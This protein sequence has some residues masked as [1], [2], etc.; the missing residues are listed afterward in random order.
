MLYQASLV[1]EGG[2]MAGVYTAGVL[3]VLMEHE[4]YFSHAIGVSIGSCNV[5]DFA[6]RQIGRTI[7]CMAVKDKR[8]IYVFSG[9]CRSIYPL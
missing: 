7:D 6:S 5:V 9:F 4:I 2:A 8:L 1:C 3:D